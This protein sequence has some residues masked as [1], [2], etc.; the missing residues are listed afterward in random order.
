M[1]QQVNEQTKRKPI[2][3]KFG[4]LRLKGNEILPRVLQIKAETLEAAV[5]AEDAA[6]AHQ[7]AK[8]AAA[9][10]KDSAARTLGWEFNFDLHEAAYRAIYNHVYWK[11]YE[12]LYPGI[13][14]AR[15][16]T[17][18]QELRNEAADQE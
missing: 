10:G 16:Q 15:E 13:Y 5:D 8:Q 18:K 14:V 1:E 12:A 3:S 6:R 9:D 2:R 7:K 4:K 11:E 17:A